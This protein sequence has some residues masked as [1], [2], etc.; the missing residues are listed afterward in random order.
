MSDTN[1]SWLGRFWEGFTN[2]FRGPAKPMVL[3]KPPVTPSQMRKQPADAPIGRPGDNVEDRLDEAL[4]E[5][6]PG[7]DPISVRIE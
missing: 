2:L 5:T 6:M 3:A 4:E 1:R 7:S